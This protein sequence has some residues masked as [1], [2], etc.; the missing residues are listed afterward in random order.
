MA[1]TIIVKFVISLE[2]PTNKHSSILICGLA[3]LFGVG[4]I[5]IIN[6]FRLVA[7]EVP[8]LLSPAGKFQ[9]RDLKG[10]LISFDDV[11][12]GQN[13]IRVQPALAV[14]WQLRDLDGKSVRFSDF[15]GKVV[16]LNFWATWCPPCKKELP[17]LIQLQ[18][19]FGRRSAVV[20]GVS[21][22][23][24][25]TKEVQSFATKIGINYPVIMGTD[26]LSEQYGADNGIPIT[27]IIDSAGVI[28]A[29]N[30][31]LLDRQATEL[32]INQLLVNPQ[33][34]KKT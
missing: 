15:K 25:S 12:M 28:I 23:S 32:I 26:E 19:E 34:T 18:R 24:V 33:P 2:P 4:A 5:L 31:G 3:L 13:L 17:D 10:H 14:N 27:Y 11:G 29:V 30:P 6:S 1:K 22:D 21:V 9:L 8:G 20:V 7:S 16:V